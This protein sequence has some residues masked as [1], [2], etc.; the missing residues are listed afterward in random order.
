M[1][2]IYRL[3]DLGRYQADEPHFYPQPEADMRW[4]LPQL[5]ALSHLDLS[6]SNLAGFI[7]DDPDDEALRHK[8][9]VDPKY[10]KQK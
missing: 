8:T 1:I 2:C 3:L 5:P 9:K 7:Q 6:G 4:L 10:E